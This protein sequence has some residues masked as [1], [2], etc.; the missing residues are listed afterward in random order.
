MGEILG[1][2]IS[3]W[4][5]LGQRNQD[6]AFWLRRTLQ[7]PEIPAALKD[8]ANWTELARYEWG[9][10]EGVARAQ[11][12]RDAMLAGL[13]RV[14]SALDAFAPDAVIVWGDDQYENFREDV[15]PA[16]C[17]LAY[18][19]DQLC[20]PFG[21]APNAWGEGKETSFIVKAAPQIAKSL[22]T[23]MLEEGFDIAYA[24]KPLHFPG[25]PHAFINAVLY[26]DYDRRGFPYPVIP[27]QVNC[28]GR[29]VISHRGIGFPYAEAAVPLDPPAPSP[30]RCFDLGRA[31]AR[32]MAKSPHRVA[33]VASS[34]WSHAFLCDRTKHLWPDIPADRKLYDALVSGN[35]EIWRSRPLAEIEL[36]GQ[37]E[38]LNWFCLFGA[39]TELSHVV[40]WSEFVETYVFN[41]N[42]VAA[43]F[44]NGG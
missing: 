2:G 43:I 23:G 31:V 6:M 29:Y 8:P 3:H 12:H 44:G 5:R 21:G 42:K 22:A 26:L 14:R 4:P 34:S 25:L 36:S 39:M 15:I 10:D 35:W 16:F 37:H 1:L 30:A 32:V 13:R 24:Y 27:F 20:K 41:S 38:L 18:Q 7:D 17:V 11:E 28:Y 19:D 33:L 40:S 9:D